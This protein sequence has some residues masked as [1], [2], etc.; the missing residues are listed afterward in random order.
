GGE[1]MR[2]RIIFGVIVAV[3]GSALGLTM[4]QA[5]SS[6]SAH[7]QHFTRFGDNPNVDGIRHGWGL[8]PVRGRGDDVVVDEHHDRFVFAK[9]SVNLAH[10]ITSQHDSFDG[11]TC[12]FQHVEQGTY[13]IA[14][15]TGAY[16][17]AQG[18][19]TYDLKVLGQG[20][21]EHQPP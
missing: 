7:T 16:A 18:N 17:H 11:P 4:S 19:G 1:P 9:G 8:R 5:S 21:D 2:L 14:G 20:C 12:V 13:T 10:H 3:I 15:G 6:P